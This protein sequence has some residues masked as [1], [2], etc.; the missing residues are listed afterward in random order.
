MII[1]AKDIEKSYNGEPCLRGVNLEVEEGK[2]LSVMGAS[3]SGK[4]TLME[5][6]SGVRTPDKGSVTIAGHNIFALTPAQTAQ[7][8]RTV[9]GVVYQHFSLVSTLTAA[10]NIRLPLALEGT[11]RALFPSRMEELAEALRLSPSLLKKT[12][13]ELSGGQC[14]RVAIARAL[15]IRPKVLLLDEPTGSLDRENTLRVLQLLKDFNAKYCA[16][17]VQ[18]THSAEAAEFACGKSGVIRIADGVIQA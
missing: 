15:I 6:L 16:T 2:F 13:G 14:Q 11:D 10:D 18:I 1:Q 7:L 3:G 8:R 12:P 17:V 9:V 5:I 4:T